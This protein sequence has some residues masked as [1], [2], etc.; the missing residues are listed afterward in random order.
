MEPTEDKRPKPVDEQA[1]WVATFVDDSREKRDPFEEIWN[2]TELNFLVRNFKENTRSKDTT[3][4]LD[5]IGERKS[6]ALSGFSVL[7]DPETHQ[8]VM[9]IVAKIV[10]ALFPH[11]GFVRS[12]RVGF[13][14]IFKAR[15]VNQLIEY[16]TRLPGNYQTFF[17]WVL[18][19]GIYGTGIIEAFWDYREEPR[20]FRTIGT[21]PYGNPVDTEEILVAPVFDDVRYLPVPIRD[22]FPD[23]GGTRISDMQG[24]AKRFRITAE[25]ARRRVESGLYKEDAVERAL[26]R[27]V[28]KDSG[29]EE[30]SPNQDETTGLHV[31]ESHH[32]FKQVIGYEYVGN[33]PFKTKDGIQRRVV[34]VLGG[35]T[36]RSDPWPRRLPW[37]EGRIIPRLGSFYGIAPAEIIRFDQDFADVLKRMLAD[38]VVRMTHPPH[39]VKRS[40][41]VETSKLRAFRPR[42]PVM[43][44]QMDAVQQIDYAPPIGPAF[45]MWTSAKQQMREASGALGAVQ[46]LGMGSKRFSASEAVF[47]GEQ[48]LDRPELF[49][50]VLE[51]EYLP[52]IGK[53]TLALYQQ[54]LED[55]E[56]LQLRI[57]ESETQASLSD[58]LEDFDVRFIG[59]R[60][61]GGKQERI[62]SAREIFQASANPLV[63]QVIPWI[64]FLRKYF[65]DIGQPEL[66]AMVG[67]PQLVQLNMMLTQIGGQ[68]TQQMGNGANMP[69][70]QPVGALPAQMEGSE[71]E[72]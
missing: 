9:T 24:C 71:T 64:P 34:T 21:D 55:D 60:I 43:T 30:D 48:A 36:V 32:S 6:S 26:E 63:A 4:P 59:S 31:K 56:D 45:Q 53:Y 68:P 35:E 20:P 10:L 14:D 58:V 15:V 8:E 37:F 12:R 19:M 22:F 46:G 2:E 50:T 61:E 44:D 33:V 66:A 25:L 51:R 11:D 39:L 17:E 42:V 41:G 62:A 67:N 57:G 18:S 49:A 40:A 1:D 52:P 3:A 7:K 13:E 69:T 38:A 29:E 70:G 47:T 16:V 23:P 54:L 27:M 5:L 72:V 28:N 65:E